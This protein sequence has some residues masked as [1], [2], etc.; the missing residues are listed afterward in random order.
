MSS[1]VKYTPK[2]GVQF[3]THKWKLPNS[4]SFEQNVDL[5]WYPGVYICFYNVNIAP[6]NLT[7]NY[8]NNQLR[9]LESQFSPKI[10]GEIVPFSEI[11]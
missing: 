3:K 6:L 2:E 8:F 1:Y 5:K 10:T 4:S 9:L 7:K 11:F